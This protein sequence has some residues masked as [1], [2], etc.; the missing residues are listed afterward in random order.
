M[1]SIH[2]IL[3]MAFAEYRASVHIRNPDSAAYDDLFPETF[4]MLYDWLK[5]TDPESLPPVRFVL[6]SLSDEEEEDEEDD[7]EHED[8]NP[9]WDYW[10]ALD[11]FDRKLMQLHPLAEPSSPLPTEQEVF[12]ALLKAYRLSLLV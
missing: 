3:K 11:E 7:E 12:Q 5:E 10:N 1:H 9:T 4:G 8:S 2:D 6:S